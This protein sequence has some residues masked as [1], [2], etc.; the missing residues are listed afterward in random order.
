MKKKRY[1]IAQQNCENQSNRWCVIQRKI[2]VDVPEQIFYCVVRNAQNVFCVIYVIK[3][4]NC[5][6]SWDIY[7]APETILTNSS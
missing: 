6:Q 1:I 3:S 5:K 7:G 4:H 2:D